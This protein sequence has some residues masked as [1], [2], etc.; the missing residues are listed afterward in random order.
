M[1]RD[2]DRSIAG[3]SEAEPSSEPDADASARHPFAIAG[4]QRYREVNVVGAGGLGTVLLAHDERLARDVALKRM[5]PMVD[6][7]QAAAQFAREARI[8]ARL[9]HPG[10]VPIHDAGVTADGR[11]FYTMRLIRGRSLAELAAQTPD[12]AARVALTNAV[13]AACHAV[14]YAHRRGV[15]PLDVGVGELRYG[16][17]NCTDDYRQKRQPRREKYA[18][19]IVQGIANLKP[20][21]HRDLSKTQ[22]DD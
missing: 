5:G 21:I 20:K 12:L 19:A 8:T 10:I 3:L 17:G 2:G 4:E 1:A 14:G 16:C 13:A 9:D 11:L 6:A 22:L 18:H 15:D 7:Q